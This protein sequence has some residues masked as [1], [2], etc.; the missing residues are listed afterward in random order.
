MIQITLG[1][2]SLPRVRY[3]KN[4][5][6]R[7]FEIDHNTLFEF[8]EQ[9]CYEKSVSRK[10]LDLPVFETPALP[11]GTVKYMAMPDGKVALFMEKKA[12]S[13]DINY[14]GT[15]FKEVP[16]PNL[17]F[18][19]TF[20]PNQDGSFK[21]TAKKVF[22]FKGTVLREDTELFR[23]PFAHVYAD[24]GMC[25]HFQSDYK[26]LVQ[27]STFVHHW[28]N[29]EFTDHFYHGEGVG[30]NYW[31]K[32]QREIFTEIQGK[33]SFEYEQLVTAEQTMAKLVKQLVNGYFPE[34]LQIEEEEGN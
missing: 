6:E 20:V 29:A 4:G 9:N 7:D 5:M 34:E 3:Q 11:V 33:K 23:W 15:V 26:D 13:H 10:K 22:T 30:R 28:L 21:L 17:L 18:M 24:G 19:F 14:H 31:G 27:L 25:F 16:L 32:T 1:D 12:F 8:I 2:E